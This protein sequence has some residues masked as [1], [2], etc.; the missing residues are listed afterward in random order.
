MSCEPATSPCQPLGSIAPQTTRLRTPD[1]E[2]RTLDSELPTDLVGY[3]LC[4]NFTLLNHFKKTTICLYVLEIK[5]PISGRR[6]RKEKL[7]FMN[8]SKMAGVYSFRILP[9][10]RPS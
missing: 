4:P 5:R 8:S 9:T 1:S 3:S 10:I 2:L 7:I 6:Q